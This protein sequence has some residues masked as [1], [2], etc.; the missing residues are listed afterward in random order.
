VGSRVLEQR[1]R[2]DRV[3]QQKIQLTLS[4]SAKSEVEWEVDVNVPTQTHTIVQDGLMLDSVPI[5]I[6]STI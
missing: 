6:T 5:Q 2:Q 1:K 4:L 3:E